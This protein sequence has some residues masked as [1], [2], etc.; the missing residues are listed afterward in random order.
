MPK[1]SFLVL[2]IFSLTALAAPARTGWEEGLRAD[3]RFTLKCEI[4]FLSH[5]NVRT[6][7]DRL[8]VAAKIHCE[9]NWSFDAHREDESQAFVFKA[10]ADPKARQC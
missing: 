8:I 2:L 10:C 7:Q 1:A 3:A 5:V 4:A 9:D 6:F